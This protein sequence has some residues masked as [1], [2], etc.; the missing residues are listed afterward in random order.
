MA[1]SG[2][3]R[4]CALTSSQHA[5]FITEE[6]IEQALLQRLLVNEWSYLFDEPRQRAGGNVANPGSHVF[7]EIARDGSKGMSVSLWRRALGCARGPYCITWQDYIVTVF[8]VTLDFSDFHC[9]LTQ[10]PVMLLESF[11][12]FDIG[13][14]SVSKEHVLP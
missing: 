5:H 9:P 10:T 2:S 13:P 14:Q 6:Q 11:K 3:R 8:A 1:R 7:K 4:R 12:H